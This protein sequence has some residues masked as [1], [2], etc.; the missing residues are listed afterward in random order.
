MVLKR[1]GGGERYGET[2]PPTLGNDDG[3]TSER[4]FVKMK[5]PRHFL[6]RKQELNFTSAAPSSNSRDGNAPRNL[7]GV[8]TEKLNL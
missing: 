7:F 2:S 8:I 6:K 5:K 1:K 3:E 4:L